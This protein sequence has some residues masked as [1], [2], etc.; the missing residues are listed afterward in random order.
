MKR[1]QMRRLAATTFAA[2]SL[3]ASVAGAQSVAEF[4]TGKP[5]SMIISTGA[6]GG[7]D[8]NARLVA[9]HMSK[10]IPGKPSVVARNMP[11]AGH[12]QATNFMYVQAPKDGSHIAAILP[13]FV[14][15]QIIDGRGGQYDARQFNWLGS[16][17][18]DNMNVYVWHTASVKSVDDA[19]RTE[20]LMG[21]TGAGSYTI[22]FPTLMNKLL[23][24]KFKTVSGY[25]STNEI[26]L[27]MERG[28]V[29]GRAGNFFSS[30]KSQ[31]ADWV[32][33][34][35]ITLI[36]QIGEQRDSD[37][38]DV[39]LLQELTTDEEA[40]RIIRL[41]SAEIAMG[42]AYLTTPDVPKDRLDALRKAF[43]ATMKDPEFIAEAKAAN[44]E[45]RPLGADGVKRIADD[46]LA[47]PKALIERAADVR[48]RKP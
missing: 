10:H 48:G 16:S 22:L 5:I 35:K 31:N 17:D 9:R 45:V 32:R 34:K 6:G 36:A 12:I 11:G 40:K 44:I 33:D 28:E 19:K 14:L 13:S 3:T 21:G 2:A 26:H 8:A 18:V 7:L 41:F 30:L 43:E 47:T 20:I 24:T 1:T 46:I 39:P 38:K 42:K 27:A 29:Q 15:Y 4:Y 23:G 37:F 25:K